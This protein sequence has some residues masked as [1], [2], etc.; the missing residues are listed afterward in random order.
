MREAG[1]LLLPLA[2]LKNSHRIPLSKEIS[3]VTYSLSIQILETAVFPALSGPAHGNSSSLLPAW[4]AAPSFA[5]GI[6]A[7]CTL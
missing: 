2:Y 3:F 5:A 7:D 1:H 6:L 4:H